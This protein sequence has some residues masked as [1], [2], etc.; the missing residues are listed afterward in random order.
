MDEA[1]RADV[2]FLEK[3][4]DPLIKQNLEILQSIESELATQ[5]GQRVKSSL[6]TS[7]TVSRYIWW[8][9][10]IVYIMLMSAYLA[11]EKTIRRPLFE[12]ARALKAQ[13]NNDQ[14]EI[15]PHYY[16]ASES[17]LLINAFNEMKE[18]VDSRQLRLQ[19]ILQNTIEGIVISDAHGVIETFNPAAEKLFF[20]K[21]SEVI[22]Q[23]V[24]CLQENV[25]DISPQKWLSLWTSRDANDQ[26]FAEIRL[27][28]AKEERFITIKT[29][30]M[31]HRG[32]TYF[33]SVVS[34]VTEHKAF[35]NRLQ[36]LA[37]MD[38]LTK[39]HNRRYFTE[40]LDR[41]VDRSIRRKIYDCALIFIDLDNFKIVNDSYGHHVGD[42]VL[43]EVSRLLQ[44]KVRRGDLLARLGGDEF[45]VI[46]YDV[47]DKQAKEVA[48][49]YQT[50]VT[51]FT[52]YEQGRVLDV[53][54]TI[55]VS[56]L[57]SDVK[58]KDE[59]LNRAD[60]ACQMAK[61][62]GR[63]RVYAYSKEDSESK[64][65]LRG[66]MGLAQSI[67]EAIRN[68]SFKLVLQPIKSAIDESIYCY[69]VLIRMLGDNNKIIMPFGFLP[70]AERF[71]LM[72]GIDT[73][74]IKHSLSLMAQ[75]K[76]QGQQLTFSI[77]LSAQSIGD[78]EIIHTIEDGLEKNNISPE[79]LIFEITESNAISNMSNAT[80]FLQYLRDLGCRTAL[81]DF[82]AGYSSYAYLKDLPADFVKIDGA[83]VK[84]MDENDFN[85]AMVKSMNEIAHVMGK[86][87]IAEFVEN[88]AVMRLLKDIGVD[89][90][91]GYYLGKPADFAVE[92]TQETELSVN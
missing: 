75:Y 19:T 24:S 69:E 45:A 53:G 67:K 34:D 35:T 15:P 89:Y 36:N 63:N 41:L 66:Q 60:F 17:E 31:I 9:I 25:L 28:N 81:D 42:R 12:V 54:C 70:S 43:V 46:L 92:A 71:N 61:Q 4:I 73:W 11:F 87:T 48:Q 2:Y 21:A 65:Q 88:E 52:F 72:K 77:N 91:Q 76:E 74:V 51:D 85:L 40:E 68:D 82:G 80:Q 26:D 16:I 78:F 90:A 79:K 64:E 50:V 58:D 3:T 18:Q 14:Y 8:F 84:D 39:L 32:H 49:K 44:L 30:T 6:Q 7:T 59:F 38:S 83:F 62:M 22:G 56:T 13:A 20:K 47:D 5:L 37:D 1:W 27:F 23:S 29:S 57:D 33:I 86:Q 10:V 55:G